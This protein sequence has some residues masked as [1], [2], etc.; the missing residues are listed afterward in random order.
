MLTAPT[1]VTRAGRESVRQHWHST[2]L[3]YPD[4]HVTLQREVAAGATVCQEFEATG[5]NTGALLG[6]PDAAQTAL[7]T[8]KRVT[9]QGVVMSDVT[10]G[11]ITGQRLYFGQ[12]R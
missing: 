7:G 12:F 2:L 5:T 6:V 8:G 11:Q 4:L 1:R 3:L 9:L 10:G